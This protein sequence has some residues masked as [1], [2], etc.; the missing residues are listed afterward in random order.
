MWIF[1]NR[2]KKERESPAD[3]VPVKKKRSKSA[4]SV[5]ILPPKP[6]IIPGAKPGAEVP[7]EKVSEGPEE[8]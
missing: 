6:L 1:L 2:L 5:T 4:D 7:G 8:R 3:E